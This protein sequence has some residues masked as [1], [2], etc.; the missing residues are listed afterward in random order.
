MVVPRR[1]S[2]LDIE[3]RHLFQE[4]HIHVYWMGDRCISDFWFINHIHT[5]GIASPTLRRVTCP[6]AGIDVYLFPLYW[7]DAKSVSDGG[8]FIK[9][10]GWRYGTSWWIQ[11]FLEFSPRFE[12]KWNPIWWGYFSNGWF[13]HHLGKSAFPRVCRGWRTSWCCWWRFLLTNLPSARGPGSRKAQDADPTILE[14]TTFI[15]RGYN[16]YIVGPIFPCIFGVQG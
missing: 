2:C 5:D 6:C 10:I 4:W 8:E 7:K 1:V 16:P 14:P 9:Q 13:N 3:R 11:I 15:F 12:G